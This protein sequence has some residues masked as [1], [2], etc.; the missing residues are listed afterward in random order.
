MPALRKLQQ[1]F[2]AELFEEGNDANLTWIANH[3]LDSA[4]RLQVYR[5]NMLITLRAALAATYP[6]IQRLV[7]EGFFAYAA[8]GYRRRY[9]SASGDINEYCCQFPAFLAEFPSAAGLPY[10]AD[11][12][13][14]EWACHEVYYASH[15]PPLAPATLATV[16]PERQGALCFALHPACRLLCS[17]YPILRIWQSNQPDRQEDITVNLEEGGDCVLVSRPYLDIEIQRLSAGEYALLTTLAAGADLATACE[18]A[19]SAEPV[20][21]LPVVFSRHIA[22]GTLIEPHT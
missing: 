17:S 19:F 11:V 7:G 2:V 12:A 3:G 1:A 4:R 18:H 21:D 5:N 22:H 16:P 10:L 6:V 14:L 8:D 13:A 15:R 9:P 20:F